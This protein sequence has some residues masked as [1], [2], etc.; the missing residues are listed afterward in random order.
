VFQQEP[1][2]SLRISGFDSSEGQIVKVSGDMIDVMLSVMRNK[3]S[4]TRVVELAAEVIAA[5]ARFNGKVGASKSKVEL[6]NWIFLAV[7]LSEQVMD[8]C[9]GLER[10][11]ND[12]LT[13][14]KLCEGL[15]RIRSKLDRFVVPQGS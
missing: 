12:E 6:A 9:K 8:E 13:I 1:A 4:S 5:D 3:R 14:D 15:E 2:P 7:E 11:F 10:Q